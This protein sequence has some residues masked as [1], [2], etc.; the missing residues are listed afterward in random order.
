M[1]VSLRERKKTACGEEESVI[2]KVHVWRLKA[3]GGEVGKEEDENEMIHSISKGKA[4]LQCQ[5]RDSWKGRNES[6]GEKVK[7]RS[8]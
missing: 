6:S 8:C 1:Q 3:R 5:A 7:G 2:S 4:K